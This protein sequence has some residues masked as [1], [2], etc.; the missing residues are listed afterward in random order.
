[1]PGVAIDSVRCAT[2][3]RCA[4]LCGVLTL[5]PMFEERRSKPLED[6]PASERTRPLF[7]PGKIVATPGALDALS[8]AHESGDR[9]LHRHL[10]GDWGELGQHDWSANDQGVREGGRLLSAYRLPTGTTLWVITEWNRSATTL[11][12]PEEY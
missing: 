2:T 9:Y 11:L 3:L 4:G 10:C 7:R 8:A 12:L 1:M 5:T 6:I